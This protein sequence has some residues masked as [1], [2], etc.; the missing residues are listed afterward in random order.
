MKI[1]KLLLIYAE[2]GIFSIFVLGL[3]FLLL[4]KRSISQNDKTYAEMQ[5][6]TE[7]M[8]VTITHVNEFWEPITD[9][10]GNQKDIELYHKSTYE[11]G[12]KY[13]VDGK[14]YKGSIT[15]KSIINE[16]DTVDIR[17]NPTNPQDYFT[18]DQIKK[19]KPK[20]STGDFMYKLG[21]VM[22]IFSV[23]LALPLAIMHIITKRRLDR[24]HKARMREI[25][26]RHRQEM[27][28]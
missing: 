27:S 19:T 11:G 12:F 23:I 5:K 28:R 14:E 1:I 10:N 22:A 26:E 13:E 17:Y 9:E 2:A 15:S 7:S 18:V 25:E 3:I 4:G 20:S 24:E 21:M 16:G 8:T 6:C